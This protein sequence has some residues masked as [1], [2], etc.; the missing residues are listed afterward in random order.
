M[1]EHAAGGK[2]QDQEQVSVTQRIHRNA[3]LEGADLDDPMTLAGFLGSIAAL[4]ALTQ[5]EA[6]LPEDQARAHAQAMLDLVDALAVDAPG[7]N[8]GWNA[9]LAIHSSI[10]KNAVKSGEFTAESK[11]VLFDVA[12]RLLHTG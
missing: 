6:R 5:G 3:A 4:L 7:F 2:T 8:A 9:S 12:A 1:T 10:M 11:D